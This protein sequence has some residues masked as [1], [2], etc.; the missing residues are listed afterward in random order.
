MPIF[1]SLYN[2]KPRPF[3]Y[4]GFL[5]WVFHRPL[6]CH[7]VGLERSVKGRDATADLTVTQPLF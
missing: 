1:Q 7:V 4:L 5:V 3:N 2:R 6:P